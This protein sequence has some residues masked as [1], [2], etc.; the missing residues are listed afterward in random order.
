VSIAASL[1]IYGTVPSTAP[2]ASSGV[3]LNADQPKLSKLLAC[4]NVGTGT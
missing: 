4:G 1:L 3:P 2:A